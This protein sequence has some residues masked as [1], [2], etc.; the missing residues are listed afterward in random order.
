VIYDNCDFILNNSSS[1]SV[2]YPASS[3]VN[4]AWV[5]WKN[6]RVKFGSSSQAISVVS[7]VNIE[8]GSVIS[9]G[10]T[11]TYVFSD[12]TANV[13]DLVV[14]GFDFS[15]FASTVDLI[16]GSDAGSPGR[17]IFRNCKMPSSWS[18]DLISNDQTVQGS[19]G[20]MYN[21]AAGDTNY[22]LWIQDCYGSIKD[23]TTIVRSG[24]ATDGTTSHSWKMVS[25]ADADPKIHILYSPELF[26]R[27]DSV[28][29]SKTVTV[30][31]VHDSQGSGGSGALTDREAWLEVMYLGTSGFPLGTWISDKAATELTTAADQTS[32]SA[33][34]TTTGLGTPVKQKLSV[35]FTPQEAGVFVARVCLA[36]TSDTVYVDPKLTV[37]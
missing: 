14:S 26:K 37:T 2:I 32:S 29:S 28:G 18:G 9:G 24:G 12:S 17:R 3:A 36:G 16:R 1:S 23:E 7:M 6:C 35:T 33:T 20:E 27:N 19:R 30:E 22:A 15:N 5:E 10:S 4:A 21:C 34:W 13:F 31:I 11:P 8:G 25:D